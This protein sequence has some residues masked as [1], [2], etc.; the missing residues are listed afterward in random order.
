MVVGKEGKS[1]GIESFQQDDA[2]VG[3]SVCGGGGECHGV[4]FADAGFKGFLPPFIEL[5]E[6]IFYDLCFGEM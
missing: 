6:G 3:H 4:D 5:G 2:G 1:V